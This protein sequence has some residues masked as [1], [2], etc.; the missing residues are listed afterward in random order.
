MKKILIV[1][2]SLFLLISIGGC[3]NNSKQEERQI[4]EGKYPIKWDDTLL[5]ADENAFMADIE[6]IK[7]WP[8]EIQSYKGK[9][10]TTEGLYGYFSTYYSFD[11]RCILDKLAAYVKFGEQVYPMEKNVFVNSILTSYALEN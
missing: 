10:D 8:I 9:L 2:L 1:L 7:Q 11:Y 6:K 4:V 5:Y 3:S